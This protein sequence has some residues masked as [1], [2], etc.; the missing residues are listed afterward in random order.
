[1]TITI[2]APTK[3]MLASIA[4]R[5]CP[6]DTAELAAQGLTPLPVLLLGLE[7]SREV[8][9]ACWDGR[10]Q[11]AFGVADYEHDD[12]IGIPWML[13]T[14][15]RG[16]IVREFLAKSREYVQA[17]APMYLS[18]FNLVDVRHIRAQRWLMYLGFRPLK[19]HT[20]NHHPF[21]EFGRL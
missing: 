21:I 8:Y 10:P 20:I 6:E 14:G 9:V 15:P 11:A 3:T 2:H 16:R 17:W 12:R 7:K 1:M 4:A 13:S 19:T 18:M 5:M